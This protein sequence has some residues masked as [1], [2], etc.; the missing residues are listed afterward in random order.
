MDN[1]KKRKRKRKGRRGREEEEK[2]E[3]RTAREEIRWS[4]GK[5]IYPEPCIPTRNQIRC[6]ETIWW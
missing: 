2:E 1:K 6:R 3:E 4:K 5:F